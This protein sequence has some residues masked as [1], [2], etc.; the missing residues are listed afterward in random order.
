MGMIRKNA[1]ELPK[2]V[3]RDPAL[4]PSGHQKIDWVR[5]N[6]PL[7]NGLEKE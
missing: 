5:Y 1:G 6:M 2:T 7:L 3:I 4:A